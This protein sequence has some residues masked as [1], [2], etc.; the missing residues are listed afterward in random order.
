MDTWFNT[1]AVTPITLQREKTLLYNWAAISVIQLW[2]LKTG[3][4][5]I[6]R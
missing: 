4:S 2:E 3:A 5:I 6:L 1:C